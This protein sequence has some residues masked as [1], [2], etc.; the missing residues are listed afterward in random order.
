MLRV[1][2][3]ARETGLIDNN[4]NPATGSMFEDLVECRVCGCTDVHA[5]IGDDGVPCHWVEDDLCSNCAG[6]T[7]DD[8]DVAHVL[9]ELQAALSSDYAAQ[10]GATRAVAWA[11]Q[12]LERARFEMDVPHAKLAQHLYLDGLSAATGIPTAPRRGPGARPIEA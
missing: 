8:G 9:E 4:G 6:E 5:C 12:T 3:E 1:R 10:L 7:M 11:M 2:C